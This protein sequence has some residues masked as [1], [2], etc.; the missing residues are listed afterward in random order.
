MTTVTL[1]D[2]TKEYTLGEPA[3]ADL[4]LSVEDGELLA[5]LGPSGSGKTT[6]L[7]LIAGLLTPTRGDLLFD[8]RSVLGTQPEKRGAV[9]VFQEH[10]LFPFMSVG[11][12]VAFGLKVRGVGREAIGAAVAEALAAVRL[13]G[14]EDRWPDELSGGQRQR[15]ALARALVVRPRLLLLDEPLSNLEPVLRE[16]LRDMIRALQ[17]E[18]GITTLFVTHDQAEAVALADRIALL[19]DGRLRQVGSPRGFYEHPHDEQVARFFGGVNFLSGVK[20]GATVETAIGSLEIAT[21]DWPDGRVV[22]TIRPEAIEVGANG[23]NNVAAQIR[24]YSY[25]G[26]VAY[27]S[28]GVDGVQ[29]QVVLPPHRRFRAGE[30]IVLHLPRDRICLL[31]PGQ[32]GVEQGSPVIQGQEPFT[33]A[34]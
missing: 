25:R 15:I 28:A 9:M 16:E 31:P 1:V 7:R 12:N 3:V 20:Q 30:S 5:L 29:L 33:A 34:P 11:E 22:L 18:T 10:A 17:K 6:T 21:S 2:L 14:Y 27:C 23:H 13:E 8:G 32:Q 24:S 19:F 26:L 4:N